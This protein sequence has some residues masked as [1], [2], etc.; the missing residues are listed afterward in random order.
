MKKLLITFLCFASFFK[1]HAYY[2]E[3]DELAK[4][5]DCDTAHFFF[6]NEC[7]KTRFLA[8]DTP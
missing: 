4:C 1:F 8:L 7:I 6:K 5:V 2:K 3:R